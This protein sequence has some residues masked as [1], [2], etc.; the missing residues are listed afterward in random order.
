[1]DLAGTHKQGN[2]NFD[3]RAFYKFFEN[4][5]AVMLL[6]DPVTQYIADAN[7]AAEKFYGWGRFRLIQMRIDQI[8]TLSTEA[9][10]VEMEK[11]RKQ[12]RSYFRFKH[13]K[14]D[15]TVCPVEIFSSKVNIEGKEYL[16]SIIHDISS[17]IEAE[18]KLQ[19]N[20]KLVKN[21][22][23]QVPGVVYQYRLYPD[24]HSAFPYSSPGMWDIYEV[25]PEQ[26]LEDASPV[27]TRLHPDDYDYIARTIN[28]SAKNQTIYESEFRVILPKQGLR[29]RHCNA[30]PELMDDGSTL[31]HGIIQD[32][33]ERKNAETELAHWHNLMK[34]IIE[35]NQSAVAVHD[36]NLNYLYVSQRYLD[37]YRV[38]EKDVIGKHHY[39]VFPDLPQ[40]WRDVHQRA[41]T[42]EVIG[43]DN[44]PFYHDDGT[45]DWTRWE[46]RP[47]YEA[48]GSIGGIIVYTEVINEQIRREQE[49][50]QLNE[51]LKI[52]IEAVKELSTAQTLEAVQQIVVASA[53]KLTGSDGA[54]IVFRENE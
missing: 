13:R 10:R 45:V 53:R 38:N 3:N 49:I 23:E 40:K 42:G 17:T 12:E 2:T 7:P 33:T 46:C 24:G 25:T 18:T 9:I 8:N 52:L 6:I 16:H 1:M 15:G 14:A 21:L 39:D 11:A 35:H 26:V 54:T 50:K 19:E 36:K 47:W 32:I 5:I 44:D 29:W 27:F 34:Y 22:A 37:D 4:S 31:W 41:L 30:K 51:R 43:A 20:Y 28:E 48:D